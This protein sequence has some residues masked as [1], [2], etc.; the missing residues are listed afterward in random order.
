MTVK[1][2]SKPSYTI[3]AERHEVW[4]DGRE[5]RLA[6]KEWTLLTALHDDGGTLSRDA[7]RDILWP[8]TDGPKDSRTIDQHIARLRSKLGWDAI[9]TVT[10][11]RGYKI[12]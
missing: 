8:D 11:G 6:P 1:T 9:V 7:I 3:K 5:V 10:G 2:P 12:A 4:K